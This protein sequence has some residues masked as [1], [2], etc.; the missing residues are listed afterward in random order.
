MR[1]DRY[2]AEHSQLSRSAIA[3]LAKDGHVRIGGRA[4]EAGHRV[5]RGDEIVVDVPAEAP[6]LSLE[7]EDIPVDVL[8]EDQDVI[9]VNKPAGLV[10]H[11]AFGHSSGTLVNAL[12]GRIAAETG[13]TA[14]R[15]GIVHRL[16]KDTSGVM[17]VAKNDVAQLA[18]ARQLQGRTVR[19]EYLALV[20]GDPGAEPA[21]VEAPVTR[22]ASDRRRMVVRAVGRD[23]VTRFRR[24]AAYGDGASRQ[25]LLLAQPL[26]GRTHQIRAHLAFARTPIVGDPVYGR[27]GDRSELGRQFLHAWRLTVRL[28]HAGE[29]TFTA[30][31][32]PDLSRYLASLGEPRVTAEPFA[33]VE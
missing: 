30:P 33:E 27:R 25:A 24:I 22:D 16:D 20:W 6:P 3:R 14:A 17:I 31:L 18:L 13:R 11:P 7:A 10:V 19:K 15:P 12:V 23:A 29:R 5:H 1:V 2:V 32:A 9:V 4:V 28:P 8:Y 21:V 26:T